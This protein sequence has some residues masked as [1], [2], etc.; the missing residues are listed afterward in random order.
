MQLAG[1]PSFSP[2]FIMRAM[3]DLPVRLGGPS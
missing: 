1:Q 2:S 3:T